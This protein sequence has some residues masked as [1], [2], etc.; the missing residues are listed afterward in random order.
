MAN[1]KDLL[2]QALDKKH[3]TKSNDGHEAVTHAQQSVGSNAKSVKGA[4]K[5]TKKVTGRGR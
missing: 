2:K 1:L 4:A 3:G 5:P